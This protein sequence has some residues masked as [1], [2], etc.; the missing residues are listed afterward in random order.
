EGPWGD[1]HQLHALLREGYV[2]DAVLIPEYLAT[3]LPL[4]GRGL[5]IWEARI[6][7]DG[8]PV[9]EVFR[10]PGQPDVIAAG[11][12]VVRR[13]QALTARYAQTPHP[14]AGPASYFLGQIHA[15]EVFNQAATE[16]RIHG[17]RRWLPGQSGEA[18]RR[19]LEAVLAQVAAETGTRIELEFMSP[20]DA[21]E[22]NP[23]EPLV[24]AFRAAYREVT[25]SPPP[26]PG[27]KPFL[28]D[29]NAFM[30]RV[31]VPALTHGPDAKGAHTTQESVPFEELVRVARTYAMTAVLF[32]PERST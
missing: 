13:L 19:E 17:T 3:H 9:H 20:G 6:V 24:T 21:F 18:A 32:C 27:A 23:E 16:C 26:P 7:R 15:G 30:G 10:T 4:A 28:D 31:G 2:G 25:G 11:A 5:G 14:L 1:A 29:G 12:E 22:L 8:T